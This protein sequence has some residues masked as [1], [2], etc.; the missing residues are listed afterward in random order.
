[1]ALPLQLRVLFSME[2]TICWSD[3]PQCLLELI[4]QRLS[5]PDRLL[6]GSVCRSWC[7]AKR[8]CR[9]LP[10]IIFYR[11]VTRKETI[12]IFS[13]P[14][15]RIYKMQVQEI[16]A[17]SLCISTSHGW[18]L[19]QP[20]NTYFTS[21]LVKNEE[22]V[23]LPRLEFSVCY[24][25][26]LFFSTQ[27]DPDGVIFVR[28]SNNTFLLYRCCERQFYEHQWRETVVS[29][30][31]FFEGKLYALSINKGKNRKLHSLSDED[32]NLT[33]INPLFPDDSATVKMKLKLRNNTQLLPTLKNRVFVL[34]ESCGEILIVRMMGNGGLIFKCDVFRADLTEMEWMKVESLGDR[35]LFL[36]HGSSI[37]VSARE[38][39]CKGNRIYYIPTP[40][41]R[42]AVYR[43]FGR[44]NTPFVEFELGGDQMIIHSLPDYQYFVI[45]CAWLTP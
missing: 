3:L 17:R 26:C 34:V 23:V 30:T 7:I 19:F 43:A 29:N 42:E 4:L 14:D 39:S 5:M 38:M 40:S 44:T 8:Q 2:G 41:H 45:G 32:W 6:F 25:D 37:S 27:L 18:M 20:D 13:L 31:I 33:V 16:D 10:F 28:K 21:V 1:M 9:V 35:M 24:L 15:K 22:H 11:F 12:E 36:S